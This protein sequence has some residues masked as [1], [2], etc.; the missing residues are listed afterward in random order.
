MALKVNC[1]KLIAGND[2][3][4]SQLILDKSPE[5][6]TLEHSTCVVVEENLTDLE[7]EKTDQK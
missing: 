4:I 1:S 7:V 6:D 5:F 2:I 3:H